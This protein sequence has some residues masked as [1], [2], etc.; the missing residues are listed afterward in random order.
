MRKP[1]P[2][3]YKLALEKLDTLGKEKDGS[4]VTA[5]DCLFLDDIGE[6]LKT[7]KDLGMS[8]IK[9]VRG[10]TWRAVKELEQATGIELMDEK[11]RRSK[12]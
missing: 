9:V 5:E 8:T 4:G 7:A 3:I 6:N 11:T 2:D 10:K 1:N 12:L